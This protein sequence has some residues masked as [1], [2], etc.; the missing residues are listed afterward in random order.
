MCIRDRV[1]TLREVYA[2]LAADRGIHLREQGGWNLAQ[3][4]AAQ[5][6]CGGEAGDIAPV[7]YTHLL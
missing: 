4:Y 1:F 7:S 2:G 5:E 3:G 6:S